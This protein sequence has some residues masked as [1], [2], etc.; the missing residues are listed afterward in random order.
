MFSRNLWDYDFT[1]GT[2]HFKRLQQPYHWRK[3]RKIFVCSTGDLFHQDVSP[4]MHAKIWQVMKDN[5]QHTFMLLTKRPKR[6]GEFIMGSG[7]PLENVWFGVTAENQAQWSARVEPLR[8]VIQSAVLFVSVEPML[9]RISPQN[10]GV[11]GMDLVDW[12]ICGAETGPSKRPMDT[13]W[14]THLRDR[15]SATDTPFFF[16]KDSNGNGTLDGVEHKEFPI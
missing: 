15:C 5:P 7:G 6:M 4:I 13:E 16:K 1:P 14:A 11:S 8:N 12:V 10:C 9:S 3:P 2:F